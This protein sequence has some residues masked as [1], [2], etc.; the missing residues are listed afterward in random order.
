MSDINL[1]DP[2][3]E[4]ARRVVD[5]I[6]NSHRLSFAL[7]SR[8]RGGLNGGAWI[9]TDPDGQLAVL[10]WRANDPTARTARLVEMVNRIHATGYPTP[11]WITAGVTDAGTSYLLQEFVPGLP[12]SPLNLGTAVLL[13]DVLERQAGLDPDPDHDCSAYVTSFVQDDGD[14]GPRAFLR[15]LGTPGR[16]LLAHFDRVVAQHGQIRLPAGD[17]VHAEFQSCNVLMYDG[18]VS[19]V[20]DI[21][22]FGSGTRAIDYGDLLREAW[23]TEAG[24][25]TTHLIRQAGEAVAGPGVLAL[26]TA[27]SAFGI[28]QFQAH[29]DPRDLPWVYARLHHLADDLNRPL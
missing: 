7:H 9:L 15:G 2:A 18:K 12:A 8:C 28:V 19:G 6:N 11:R 13:V 21:Q 29:H 3:M 23:V 27:A 26:C 17:M 25:D 16:D 4:P 14:D 5:D 1:V 10:K 22:T 20:I 24:P